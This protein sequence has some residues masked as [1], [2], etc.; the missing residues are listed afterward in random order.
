M[1]TFYL[2]FRGYGCTDSTHSYLSK[3][4]PSVLF[5]TLSNLMFVPAVILATYYRLYIEALF[6]HACDQEIHRFCIFKYDGLQLADFIGSY[7]SFVITLITMSIIPRS[8]KAFLFM[9]GLLTCVTINSRDRFDSLQ[10]VAIVVIT[11][12]F[13]IVTWIV[14]SIKKHRLQPSFR[15]LLLIVPG[16][17]LAIIGIILFTTVETD[18][19]YWYVHSLWHML[20]A[21]SILFFLPRKIRQNTQNKQSSEINRN[22]P[23][24]P[25][26]II[27]EGAT[28]PIDEQDN[29]HQTN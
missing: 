20:M 29:T 28:V 9:L 6:Y 15:Q 4:L 7:S 18:D 1:N 11:F 3:Y 10:F 8:I 5:L 17:L 21:M 27:N 19:N 23:Y 22:T 12:T 25:A 24:S 14:V 2:G 16:V 26:G 13:T